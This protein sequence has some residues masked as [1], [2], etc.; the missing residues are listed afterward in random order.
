MK[1]K[2]EEPKRKRPKI[3]LDGN[4]Q[5]LESLYWELKYRHLKTVSQVFMHYVCDLGQDMSKD[6]FEDTHLGFLSIMHL[7]DQDKFVAKSS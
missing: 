1:T 5:E 2:Q 4:V 3:K 6:E 7:F